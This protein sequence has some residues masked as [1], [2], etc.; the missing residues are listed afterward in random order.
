MLGH[1]PETDPL[2]RT[3]KCVES[4]NSPLKKKYVQISKGIC[5]FTAEKLISTGMK[6][7]QPCATTGQPRY[8]SIAFIYKWGYF[9]TSIHHR[10]SN[11]VQ[12]N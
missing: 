10:L 6:V 4:L 12:H 11:C 7:A 5:L 3:K 2:R 9:S 1:C 8:S